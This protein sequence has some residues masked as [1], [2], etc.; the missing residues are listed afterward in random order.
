MFMTEPQNAN[1]SDARR[2]EPFG[3]DLPS[4]DLL[5][6][7]DAPESTHEDLRLT[8]GEADALSEIR[9]TQ[10]GTKVSQTVE[11]TG[12]QAREPQLFEVPIG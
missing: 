4:L 11:N 10:D 8:E 12:Q 1:D 7:E 3:N 6:V 5:V 9:D 2:E